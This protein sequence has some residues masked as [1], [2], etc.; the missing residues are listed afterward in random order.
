QSAVALAG[1]GQ[2]S[3]VVF[4][5]DS[6]TAR[7]A[8]PGFPGVSVWNSAIAPLGAVDFGVDGDRTQN[9][10]WRMANGELDGQ[11]KVAG[12]ELGSN[13]L[14]VQAQNE[15]PQE[16]AG[17]IS[18]V[19]Q[20]IQAVS[21]NTKIL[22]LGILPRGESPSDPARAEIQQVN[23]IISGLADGTNIV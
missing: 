23:S 20:T 9:L 13:N 8:A 17:G 4:F 21:P 19:V 1:S 12:G 22:L 16:T 10:I 7:W 15:T 14:F 2:A 6:I 3:G 11:P 18:A 5:G